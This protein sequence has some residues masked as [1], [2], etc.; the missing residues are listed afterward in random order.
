MHIRAAMQSDI[1]ALVDI[2]RAMHAESPRYSRLTFD[3]MKVRQTL[4][5]LLHDSAGFV[6]VAERGG[7]I[8]GALAGFIAPDWHSV[9]P[10]AHD[11]GLFVE[12][13][14]RGA[15]IAPQLVASFKAWALERGAAFGTCGISTGVAVEQTAAL[16]EHLGMRYVG[17]IYEFTGA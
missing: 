13:T 2:A 11:M 4:S 17:P 10:I 12:Q 6:A 8:V 5:A 9:E 14:A 15:F 3:G 1:P 16:Y 7:R